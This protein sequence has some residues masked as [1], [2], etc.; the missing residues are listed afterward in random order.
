VRWGDPGGDL[1]QRAEQLRELPDSL[2]RV[3]WG[4]TRDREHP[5]GERSG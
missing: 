4:E 5:D 1:R 3:T 2:S